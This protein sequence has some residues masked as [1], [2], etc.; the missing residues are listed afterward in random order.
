MENLMDIYS[1]E[2][3]ATPVNVCFRWPRNGSVIATR[4]NPFNA[5]ATFVQSTSMHIFW[6]P[7]KPCHVGIH[8]IALVEYSLMSTH[9][10]GVSVIFLV[11]RIILYWQN[12]PPAVYVLKAYLSTLR[13]VPICQGLSHFQGVL[14]HFVL[15]KFAIGSILVK[16]ISEY[17]QMS[18]HMPGF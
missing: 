13:W 14:H 6:K 7:S 1:C 16:G 9:M 5:E 18:T 12:L 4:V 11:F 10:P 15:A 3:T 8:G 2:H 17:S